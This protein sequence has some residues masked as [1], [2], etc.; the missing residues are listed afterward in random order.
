MPPCN[1]PCVQAEG[2]RARDYVAIHRAEL[3]KTIG[4]VVEREQVRV[5]LFVAAVG[6]CCDRCRMP[7]ALLTKC[8][9]TP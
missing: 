9:A 7:R 6:A 3:L 8:A 1:L 5:M 4:K 2:A